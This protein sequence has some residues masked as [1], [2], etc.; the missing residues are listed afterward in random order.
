[1][2]VA[3]RDHWQK[4]ALRRVVPGYNEPRKSA[5]GSATEMGVG[6]VL[7]ERRME[8]HLP[9]GRYFPGDIS[10]KGGGSYL[11]SPKSSSVSTLN[12][13]QRAA[14]GGY[15]TL[16]RFVVTGPSLAAASQRM[17]EGNRG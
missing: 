12:S 14:T 6:K 15:L 2:A 7:R 8:T 16:R 9:D 1:M 3:T 4:C 5:H 11:D 13:H 17:Q 10:Q